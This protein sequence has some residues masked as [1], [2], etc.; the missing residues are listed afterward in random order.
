MTAGDWAIG[1]TAAFVV[2]RPTVRASNAVDARLATKTNVDDAQTAIIATV[3][4]T[5]GHG[6]LPAFI[7]KLLDS[8]TEL[9]KAILSGKVTSADNNNGTWTLNFHAPDGTTV[10]HT[11]TY[12]PTTGAQGVVT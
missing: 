11:V 3:P 5:N 8:Q 7:A 6:S 10:L 1:G 2:L 12:N 4:I 9:L